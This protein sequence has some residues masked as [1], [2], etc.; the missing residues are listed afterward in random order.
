MQTLTVAGA[1]PQII[2]AAVV[3]RLLR[4]QPFGDGHSGD[5]IVKLIVN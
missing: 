3:S 2:K 5:R 4:Y 1:C